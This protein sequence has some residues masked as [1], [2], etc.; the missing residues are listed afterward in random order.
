MSD[1]CWNLTD[2]GFSTDQDR[3]LLVYKPVLDQERGIYTPISGDVDIHFIVHL[4]EFR[5][6]VNKLAFL[7]FGIVQNDPLSIYKGGYLSYQQP[8]PGTASPVRLLISGTNQATQKISILDDGFQHEVLLSIKGDR[9][10]VFLNGEQTGD[11]VSLPPTDRAFWIGYVL[12]PKSVLDVM[13]SDF[14]I[15]SN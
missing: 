5:T 7:N 10:R 13:I 2:W 9:M 11:P 15:Q 8:G 12:P 1:G 14:T 4:N 6:R 3:L